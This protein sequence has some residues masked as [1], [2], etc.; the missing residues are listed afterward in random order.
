MRSRLLDGRYRLGPVIGAGGMGAVHRAHDVRLGRDVAVKLLPAGAGAADC[1]RLRREVEYLGAVQHPNL[2]AILDG[3]AD[4]DGG[5][6]GGRGGVAWFAMELVAGPDLRTLL[7]ERGPMDGAGMRRLLAGVAGALAAMHAAGLVHRDVTPS[8]IM[9][10][11]DPFARWEAK[12]TDLGIARRVVSARLTDAGRVVGTAAY[13]S[14]EQAVG[15]EV[16]PPT[17]VYSLALVAVEALTGATPFP[18]SAVESAT[19]RLLRP[20]ALPADLDPAWRDLLLAATATDPAERPAAAAFRAA[21]LDLPEDAGRPPRRDGAPR[22]GPATTVDGGG[23][24][25]TVDV[26]SAPAG[27]R[28][29]ARRADAARDATALLPTFGPATEVLQAS[30]TTEVLLA[31]SRT[32]A[33]AIRAPARRRSR[34]AAVVTACAL[35]LGGGATV[36]TA[37]LVGTRLLARAVAGAAEPVGRPTP[38]PSSTRAAAGSGSTG[39]G[40]GSPARAGTGAD[41]PAAAQAPA[42]A[43]DPDAGSAGAAAAPGGPPAPGGAATGPDGRV[44][45][46]AP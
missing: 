39:R 4:L 36:G 21:V 24:A 31:S 6:R 5:A 22:S 9:L 43:A 13:L 35:V 33:F 8:N 3:G 32:A 10:T 30:P 34:V 11:A 41:V 44:G 16:G 23:A 37:A 42:A 19:A 14:P 28:D 38:Q 40:A 15:G 1:E 25:T 12:L 7:R 29:S 20:P 2:V 18:G 46:V 26:A 45:A 27:T 17:D